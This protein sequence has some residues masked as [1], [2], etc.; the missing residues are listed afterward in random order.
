[1]EAWVTMPFSWRNTF[2][3]VAVGR[4]HD[5]VIVVRH[6]APGV[7]EPV[8][9]V[10]HLRQDAQALHAIFVVFEDRLTPITAGRDVI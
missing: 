10:D 2:R 6:E 1:M 3:K 9:P 5:Q 8:E 4:L 7:T